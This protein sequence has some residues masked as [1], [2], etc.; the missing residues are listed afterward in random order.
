MNIADLHEKLGI[1]LPVSS[2]TEESRRY[3][4]TLAGV[5]FALSRRDYRAT[6]MLDETNANGYSTVVFSATFATTDFL[7]FAD[8]DLTLDSPA[9]VEVVRWDAVE[10]IGLNAS[11]ADYRGGDIESVILRFAGARQP[12]R[13]VRSTIRFGEGF[14][15]LVSFMLDR[16]R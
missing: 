9:P 1:S 8:R 11:A 15:E 2:R 5:I 4:E 14:N 3:Q 7:V 12:R 6:A 13:I 16:L 10:S